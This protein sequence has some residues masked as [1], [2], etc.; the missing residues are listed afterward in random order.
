MGARPNVFHQWF[1]VKKGPLLHFE[2]SAFA[3]TAGEDQETNP[4]IFGRALA[5]WV[6]EQLIGAGFH[7]GSAIAEDFGWCV[8]VNSPPYSLYVVC[9]SSELANHW[10]IFAF[11]EGGL[12]DRILRRDRST[13]LVA[14]L[15]STLRH[16]L[17][18][19][20]VVHGLREETADQ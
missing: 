18:S 17:K 1:G 20:P 15:Y 16:C 14:G 5:S 8:P 12:T 19:S 4:G 3:V 6:R 7:A 11:V 2:S 9:A 10:Q 13:A